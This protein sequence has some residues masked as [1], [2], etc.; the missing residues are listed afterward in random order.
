[1]IPN[2]SALKVKTP[3]GESGAFLDKARDVAGAR[4]SMIGRAMV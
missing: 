4:A 1:M 2:F 3:L